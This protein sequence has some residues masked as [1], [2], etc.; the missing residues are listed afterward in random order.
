MLF[1]IG[2]C[3]VQF[4]SSQNGL[5]WHYSVMFV[6]FVSYNVCDSFLASIIACSKKAVLTSPKFYMVHTTPLANISEIFIIGLS[7]DHYIQQHGPCTLW[8]AK[9]LGHYKNIDNSIKNLN[10]QKWTWCLINW[11]RQAGVPLLN[12]VTR[13]YLQQS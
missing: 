13:Y 12:C 3:L 6:I 1:P 10:I 2:K 7:W 8:P 5:S 11:L 9:H 4:N